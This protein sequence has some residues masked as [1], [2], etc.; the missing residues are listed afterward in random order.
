MNLKELKK[1]VDFLLRQCELSRE[2]PEK[3]N[4]GITIKRIGQVGG[5]PIVNIKSI[6]FGFDWNKGKII[7]DPEN[8]LREIDR[9]E[10]ALLQKKYDDL[11]FKYLKKIKEKK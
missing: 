3:I 7:I 6:N 2:D 1:T 10:W 11:G 5:T 9:D 4:V 8:D